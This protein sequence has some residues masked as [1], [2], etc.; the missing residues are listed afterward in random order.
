VCV[1]SLNFEQAVLFLSL[2]ASNKAI[3]EIKPAVIYTNADIQKVLRARALMKIEKD[4]GYTV[5]RIQLM[6]NLI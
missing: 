5:E 6:V 4:L 3:D 2:P 1:F